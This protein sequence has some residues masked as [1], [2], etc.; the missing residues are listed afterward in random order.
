MRKEKLHSCELQPLGDVDSW[1]TSL[2]FPPRVIRIEHFLH[3]CRFLYFRNN[4]IYMYLFCNIT[5]THTHRI[6]I[7]N[8]KKTFSLEPNLLRVC[9]ANKPISLFFCNALSSSSCCYHHNHLNLCKIDMFSSVELAVFAFHSLWLEPLAAARL[10]RNLSENGIVWMRFYVYFCRFFEIYYNFL[11]LCPSY[12]K[13]ELR[14][15]SQWNNYI[16]SLRSD[17]K[18]NIL[19]RA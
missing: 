1:Q 18:N 7:Q 13:T 4:N 10:L 11:S 9:V 16:F 5:Q 17:H 2:C 3:A 12:R 19:N 8:E 14:A 6:F 15:I